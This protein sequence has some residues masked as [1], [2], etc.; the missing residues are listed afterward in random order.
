M[1]RCPMIS[2]GPGTTVPSPTTRARAAAFDTQ[3]IVYG[4]AGGW[5]IRVGLRVTDARPARFG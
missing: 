5:Q 4:W 3:Y 1:L 2:A